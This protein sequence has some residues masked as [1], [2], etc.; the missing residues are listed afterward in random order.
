MKRNFIFLIAFLSIF[1]SSLFY[2][3][4][5]MS[6]DKGRQYY[7][8]KGLVL[9]DVQTEEKVVA[10]TFDDGPHP[11]YTAEILDLLQKYDAKATF[12]II[13]ANA[14][15]N[16][17]LLVRQYNEGHELANHTFTHTYK[18]P[19]VQRLM[20]EL[21]QTN[22]LIF[23]ITGYRP[24]LFR[25]VGGEYTDNMI[26]AAVENGYKVIMWSWHQDTQDWKD[27]GVN[28]IV[29]KVLDGTTPGDVI[30]F[31]DGGVNR[32]QTVKALEQI[33]PELQKQGYKFVTVSELMDGVSTAKHK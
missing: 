31:H 17:D 3:Q 24:T 26:N 15:K 32:G 30:L 29:R 13:G 20:K 2:V 11:K 5:A 12:F 7:E 28:K 8:E 33:L 14:E 25:P 9:W 22:E 4:I 10:L 18:I 6:A 23:N 27:P 1:I 21:E 16:P 19:S